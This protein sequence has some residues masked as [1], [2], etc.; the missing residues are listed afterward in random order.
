ML[1]LRLDESDV[2]LG[3]SAGARSEPCWLR[4]ATI[5][6]PPTLACANNSSYT[7]FINTRVLS[8]IDTS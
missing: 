8:Q 1:D 4:L 2:A 5:S 6:F 3:V 7:G